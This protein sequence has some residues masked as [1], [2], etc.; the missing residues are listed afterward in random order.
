MIDYLCREELI[1]PSLTPQR[2]RGRARLFSMGDLVWMRAL[3]D[4]LAGGMSVRRLR[5]GLAALRHQHPELRPGAVPAR[6]LVTDGN[7][8][9]FRSAENVLEDL[10]SGGQ[11]AFTFVLE[12][13][14][15]CEEL[16]EAIGSG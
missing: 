12:I 15:I 6:F 11:L 9:Y 14:R 1:V 8:L 7:H 3:R 16:A 10:N 2:G 13:E 5:D 4:L